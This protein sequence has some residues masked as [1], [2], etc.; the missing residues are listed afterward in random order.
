MIVYAI[1]STV[2]VTATYIGIAAVR[3]A[4][5][6]PGMLTAGGLAWPV[7]CTLAA[8]CIVKIAEGLR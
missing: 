8:F 3:A 6:A 4:G 1:V 7:L 2:V 5:G